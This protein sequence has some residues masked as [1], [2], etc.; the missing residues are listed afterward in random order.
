MFVVALIVAG[1]LALANWWSRW[2]DD[3]R[4]ELVTKPLTTIAAIGVAL[5]ASGPDRPT[6]TAVAALVLCLIGDVALMKVVDK[7]VVGLGA[8]LLG[9]I[10]F[11]GMFCYLGLH[12][13][14]L[15]GIVMVVCAIVVALFGVQILRGATLQRLQKPVAMYLLVISTMCVF[16]WATEN[17]LVCLGSAAFIISDTILGWRTFVHE[18]K[19]SPV[20]IMVTYHVAIISLAA[21]LAIA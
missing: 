19:W 5:A 15:A 11:I 6:T 4:L 7:F 17:W 1:V 16:G 13:W 10:V 18:T 20:A 12:S 2:T 21:S 9:H 14:T 8:F 3:G